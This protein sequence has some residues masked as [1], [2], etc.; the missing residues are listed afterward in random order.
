MDTDNSATGGD[1]PATE[2]PAP[3]PYERFK[4][5]NDSANAAKAEAAS[6]NARAEAAEQAWQAQRSQL[7]SLARTVEERLPA[8][9]PAADEWQD[10]AEVALNR[11]QAL[12]AW[13]T[14]REAKDKANAENNAA[15]R[16]I[17]EAIAKAGIEDIPI[18][19]NEVAK[20]YYASKQIG[21][22]FD[23][24]KVAEHY[25]KLELSAKPQADDS[26]KLEAKRKAAEATASA[27]TGQSSAGSPAPDA[28]PSKRPSRLDADWSQES[29]D[30]WVADREATILAKYR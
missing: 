9:A 2:T 10:P 24:D 29:E 5:V 14:E 13:K 27:I 18:W 8:P 16:L 3:V 28:P 23:A 19:G 12:E 25:R 1:T 6:A 30:A 26:A 7:D 4:E 11:V 17:D 20:S 15:R 22:S 21:A